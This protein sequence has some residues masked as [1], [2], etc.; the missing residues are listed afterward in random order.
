MNRWTQLSLTRR[1]PPPL[2]PPQGGKF[3]W[4][5]RSDRNFPPAVHSRGGP[6]HGRA[7]LTKGEAITEDCR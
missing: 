1:G 6:M 2:D 3:G 5:Q 4:C 7:V